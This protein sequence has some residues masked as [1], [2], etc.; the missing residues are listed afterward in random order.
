LGSKGKR[1]DRKVESLGFPKEIK[2]NFLTNIITLIDGYRINFCPDF[3]KIDEGVKKGVLGRNF[4]ER[5]KNIRKVL[6]SIGTFPSNIPKVKTMTRFRYLFQ[7]SGLVTMIA[8]TIIILINAFFNLGYFLNAIGMIMYV[9]G[10]SLITLGVLVKRRVAI[11]ISEYY[12]QDNE[13]FEKEQQYLRAVTQD[14]ING[15][16]RY[17]RRRMYE[18][19]EKDL[20]GLENASEKE[21]IKKLQKYK[22]K[23]YNDDYTG[24]KIIKKPSPIRK[25]FLAIP[26]I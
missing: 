14:L 25:Y 17:L 11:K 24:V 3:R 15:L 26:A 16:I 4:A 7:L 10:G 1:A 21:Y 2:I 23:L 5:W 19:L 22:F 12:R 6:W 20:K 18:G 8:S 9:I 13:R